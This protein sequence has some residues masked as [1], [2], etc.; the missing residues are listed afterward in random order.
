M[1]RTEGGSAAQGFVGRTSELETV[2]GVLTEARRGQGAALLVTGD[3]GV[4]KTRL[5]Q[6]ACDSAP[7]GFLV[8]SGAGLPMS[9][10]T[11]PLL[12]VRSAF[13][14]LPPQE[15]PRVLEGAGSGD[16]G[17]D[18]AAE[19]DAWFDRRAEAQPVALVVDDL[20]WADQATLDVLL[21]V[22]AGITTRRIALLA[23]VRR[24][25][26]PEGHPLHRWLADVRRMP[27]F[28]HLAL[29]PLD[30][31][32]TRQQVA[33]VLGDIPH[34]AL[35]REVFRRTGGNAYLNRLLVEGLPSNATTLGEGL[36]EDLATAVLRAWHR[37]PADS[38]ELARVVAVGGQVARGRTLEYAA[39]LAMVPDLHTALRDCLDGGLLQAEGE[40]GYWFHHPLQPQALEASLAAPERRR[41]HASFA[42][43]FEQEQPV[44]EMDLQTLM[45]IADH[46]DRAGHVRESYAWALRAAD[47]AASTGNDTEQVALLR[48]ALELRAQV[49]ASGEPDGAAQ[50]AVHLW[51]Q[52]RR[53]AESV[54]DQEA[55]LAAVEA[56][57]AQLDEDVEPLTVAELIVRRQ[58]LRF[59]TAGFFLDPEEVRRA[60]TLSATEPGSW[61]HAFALAELAHASLW[62]DDAEAPGLAV[63]AL[64]RARA[65]GH[66]RALAYALAANA[67]LATLED[68]FEEGHELGGQGVEAAAEARDGWAFAHAAIWEANGLETPVSPRWGASVGRRRVQLERLA[69]AHPYVAWLASVEATSR[70]HGGDWQGCERLLRLALGAKPGALVD[71]AARL[72]A[73]RLAALQGRT[74]EAKGHL[75]RADELF[76]ETSTFLPFEFDA[77]RAMVR[78]SAGDLRGTV[79]AALAGTANPGVPPTMC[80][81]L[82]PLAARALADLAQD[83][84]DVGE[85]ADGV[86]A[87]VDELVSRFPHVIAEGG[88]S[89]FYRRV[90]AALDALYHAEVARAR[91]APEARK[92]WAEATALLDG[93]LAWEE[94]YALWR[95]AEMIF[96]SDLGQ[97]DA[98]ARCLRRSHALALELGAQPVLDEV[99]VL[100]RS[101]RIALRDP[102]A[103]DR[104][105]A[106]AATAGLTAR[107]TEILGH[108]VAG[109]TYG[110]IAQ[111][112]V[113]S[114]KTVSSHVSNLQRKT[115]S[116]NRVD[117]ARWALH[118]PADED[119]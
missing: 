35:V 16:V 39:E 26:V 44:D 5:V 24:G 8:L 65:A 58:H 96:R 43:R 17:A 66:P 91:Q 97:R 104:T 63:T 55:E 68:R 1:A 25:E 87:E 83:A 113:V 77:C 38:R 75:A 45:V 85:A 22:V 30:L 42:D 93:V 92:S 56:L 108:I 115:A 64:E 6:Q 27:G 116:A 51:Q 59:S 84:R 82:L 60:V 118:Q 80:E 79:V 46:H 99:E 72:T 36:P 15:R 78:L 73:A 32:E 119:G 74:R 76:A 90:L 40:D 20:Q 19:I 23:T 61:Q 89:D 50:P 102:T 67:M 21:W 98:A 2:H 47:R 54:G 52:L 81:W 106:A 9:S 69:V 14:G 28:E 114:E 37:L 107:E 117:L 13:R 49:D 100:A 103:T 62:Q 105:R 33:D 86:V 88:V 109:R 7:G 111:D 94:C 11:V 110:E 57:L 71:V 70:L 48:R 3:A 101:A 10:L 12:P 18:A 29:G 53:A 34:D 4:G 112:L 41:L 95:E 31:A